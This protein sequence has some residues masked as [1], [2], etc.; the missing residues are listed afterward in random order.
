MK[1]SPILDQ[2]NS[3][4]DLK[5]LTFRE[6][7][8]LAGEIRNV[9]MKVV[10][11]NGGHLAS[12]LGV[13]E[14]TL[15]LHRVFDS[16][17]DKI[18]W[19]VGHQSYSHKIITGR[20]DRFHTLRKSGGLSG[21][22][23]RSESLHDPVETGHSSTSI[24]SALGILIGQQMSGRQGKVVAV[25]GDGALT[26]GMAYEALN[27]AGHLN[28]DLI[29]VVNDNN[30]SI[31]DNIGAISSYL[32]RLTATRLY[33][34]F[35]KRF[36]RGVEQIPII[37]KEIS[38][39]IYRL[40]K[41]LKALLFRESFFSDLGFDYI[42]PIDGHNIR[43]LVN[44]FRNVKK[45][46]K[47]T[48]I[49]VST[50]KGKGY[51]PAEGDPTLYHGVSPFSIVD[52]KVE[53][54]GLLTFTEAFSGI[55]TR[56]AEEDEKIVA[57]TAAM[58]DGTGLRL[59]QTL[60]PGRFFDV[61]IAEQHAVTFASGLAISG[62]RPI[63]AIYSTFMQRAVDQVIHDVALPE[64]PVI[65]AVDRAGLVGPDGETH[66]GVF[67]IS[68]F[69]SV[70]GLTILAPANMEEMEIMFRY[71]LALGKPV[72][73]RF[74]KAACGPELKAL[75]AP[76]VR[77]RGVFVQQRRDEVLII[78][79]GG[80]ISEALSA[81]RLLNGLKISADVYNLRFIKPLDVDYLIDLVACYRLVYFCE[82][83][84]SSGGVG[85]YIAS[86]LKQK[87][88]E[89]G[90]FHLGVPDRFIPQGTRSEL[91][92]LCGL[93]ANHIAAAIE[94]S[95]ASPSLLSIYREREV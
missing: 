1:L 82:E 15:A 46:D 12:N 28:N 93:D 95:L 89:T 17:V 49:H 37:G 90:F 64:L 56:L 77:G 87:K 53:T 61:G 62:Q 18:I 69:R 54:K 66:Q 88:L 19:D 47:P 80:L 92:T 7:S 43:L 9:I 59:F 39:I 5:C 40:K 30:M 67:D 25:I 32:S 63:V 35:R 94:Q 22:P 55:I 74:P 42:G 78:T 71:A 33:Q 57:V 8:S 20:R 73:I 60:Y 45:L 4:G 86:L 14:L 68:I 85:E 91:L 51:I 6:L 83:G 16:P 10:S 13:V 79:L 38:Q 70:A 2:I 44:V 50:V 31:G 23:K 27:Q 36:D 81:S 26:G 75:S 72:M 21:F 29:I 52:G 24:S 76:L 58:T 48:V 41:G 65:F 34:N 84:S 11:N 3:P